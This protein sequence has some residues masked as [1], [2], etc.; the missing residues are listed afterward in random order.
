MV[1]LTSI[2]FLRGFTKLYEVSWGYV[3]F[4]GALPMFFPFLGFVGLYKLCK[5]F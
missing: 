1:F 2:W 3:K 5:G 4:S